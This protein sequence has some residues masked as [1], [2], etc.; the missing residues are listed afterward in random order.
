[1]GWISARF[2][3][4]P[5]LFYGLAQAIIVLAVTFG[6][7]LSPEQT[8]A[9]LSVAAIIIAILTRQRVTPVK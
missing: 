2:N 3:E 8:G 6:A 9:I 7:R 5:V 4:E 1:M